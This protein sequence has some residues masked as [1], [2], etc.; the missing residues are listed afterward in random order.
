MDFCDV[1]GDLINC[2]IDVGDLMNCCVSV[3]DLGKY[4]VCDPVN[5]CV[6]VT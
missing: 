5:R 6:V 1:F 4:S 3:I 2:C